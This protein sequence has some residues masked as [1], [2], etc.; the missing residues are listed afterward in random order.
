MRRGR[1]IP[2]PVE[3]ANRAVS[4]VLALKVRTVDPAAKQELLTLLS[5]WRDEDKPLVEAIGNTLT[6]WARVDSQDK[7]RRIVTTVIEVLEREL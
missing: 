2:E 5:D 6:E 4:G 1:L 3:V 7:A